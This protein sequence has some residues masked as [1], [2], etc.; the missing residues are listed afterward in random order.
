MPEGANMG[1]MTTRKKLLQE[2]PRPRVARVSPGPAQDSRALAGRGGPSAPA[3][4]RPTTGRRPRPAA[5]SAPRRLLSSGAGA[6]SHPG[7]CS[8]TWQGTVGLRALPNGPPGR[9]RTSPWAGSS[10]TAVPQG[11]AAWCLSRCWPPATPPQLDDQ[12]L[13]RMAL[14]IVFLRAILFHH[15]LGHQGNPF[16]PIGVDERGA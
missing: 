8:A 14:T 9:A 11:A 5:P 3:R 7:R 15:G 16:T 1:I 12:A 6:T 13:G 10:G 4:P 2:G